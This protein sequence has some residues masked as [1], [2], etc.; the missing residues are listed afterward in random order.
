MA[1]VRP[2]WTTQH[3]NLENRYRNQRQGYLDPVDPCSYLGS[4]AVLAILLARGGERICG[5]GPRFPE[6]FCGRLQS[7]GWMG[8]VMGERGG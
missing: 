2:G 7:L 8:V 4:L 6:T 5:E 1:V 3:Q